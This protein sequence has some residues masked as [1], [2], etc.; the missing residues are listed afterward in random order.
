MNLA[1]TLKAGVVALALGGTALTA[2]APVQAAPPSANFQLYF[3]GG[4]GGITLHF[5]D[6]DYWDYCRTNKQIVKG[7]NNKGYKQVKIVKE[8]NKTN[9]VWAVGRKN[10]D[11][12]QLRV[13][14][15]SGKVDQV[16]KIY[17]KNNG[18]SFNLTF[19]F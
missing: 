4:N 12:Y 1:N 16:K 7:L 2:A 6:D 13:D 9:K 8:S 17:P 5:G 18:N 14:R 3:G 19:T 15:C 11:W 10:G